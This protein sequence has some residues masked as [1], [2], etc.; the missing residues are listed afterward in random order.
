MCGLAGVAGNLFY[1]DTTV[2]E[3][4]L[5]I[6]VLR[7][8]DATGIG[9]YK[10]SGPWEIAK[11]ACPSAEFLDMNRNKRLISVNQDVIMGHTRKASIPSTAH[12][13]QHAQPFVY[14]NLLACHNGFIN[15]EARRALP[16]QK[17]EMQDSEEAIYN[18][19]EEG[20][21]S[22]SPKIWGAWA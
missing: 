21:E 17:G 6:S 10:K 22:I 12:L 3:E 1:K 14:E 16:H 5:K 2:F 18:M 13:R 19:A 15:W 20:V 11:A 7:G 8:D 4:L 9:V